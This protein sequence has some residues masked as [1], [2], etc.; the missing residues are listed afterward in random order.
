MQI[1]EKHQQEDSYIISRAN[2]GNQATHTGDGVLATLA[3]W[4]RDIST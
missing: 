2:K 3:N 4:V 1:K